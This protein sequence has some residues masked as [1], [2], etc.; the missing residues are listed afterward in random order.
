MSRGKTIKIVGIVILLVEIFCL[1]IPLKE[2]RPVCIKLESETEEDEPLYLEKGI[3]TVNVQY[4][5]ETDDN[6]LRI[7]TD[8]SHFNWIQHNDV[9]LHAWYQN[10]TSTLW[11]KDEQAPI[12][13]SIVN[14][15]DSV[16]EPAQIQLSG[17][18]I[19][20]NKTTITYTV[21][22]W[23]VRFVCLDIVLFLFIKYR[24]GMR[25]SPEK[26]NGILILGMILIA[27]SYPLFTN[28]LTEGHDKIYHLMRIETIKDGLKA[29]MFPV[30]IDPSWLN[31][32]GYPASV[33]Y[34]D[35]LM[36]PAAILRLIGLKLQDC[37]K[38]YIVMVN[39]L[40]CWVSYYC[41]RQIFQNENV[42]LAGSA[43][44]TL[45]Y[46]RFIDI[47]IRG[48]AGEYTAMVFIPLVICGLYLIYEEN[49]AKHRRGLAMAVIG[50]TGLLE[51]HLLTTEIVGLFTVVICLI[52]FKRT[53]QKQRFISLCKVVIYTILVNAGFLV[54]LFDYYGRNFYISSIETGN[55]SEFE[56]AALFPTQLFQVF[57]TGIGRSYEQSVGICADMPITCG[58]VLWIIAGL[59]LYKR[60]KTGIERYSALGDIMLGYA[61][62]GAVLTTTLF[63]YR[64]LSKY[65]PIVGKLLGS[66]Q[67]PWR[68]LIVPTIAIAVVFCVLLKNMSSTYGKWFMCVCILGITML[69][70]TY[71][72]DAWYNNHEPKLYYDINSINV[73]TSVGGGEYLLLGS[74]ASNMVRGQT[75]EYSGASINHIEYGDLEIYL[76]CTGVPEQETRISLPLSNYYGYHAEDVDS[77]TEVTVENG[78]ENMVTVVLPAGYQGT[79][80]VKWS[81]PWYWR[82]AELVSLVSVIAGLALWKRKNKQ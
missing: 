16:Q 81:E 4:Q 82:V 69:S 47:Y 21:F 25:I 65:L 56:N 19:T 76:D 45:S 18:T 39:S 38:F 67:F 36:Y 30:K 15:K 79:M 10:E 64:R 40:T 61:G 73:D 44:Y 11:V 8:G 9:T 43:L 78:V 17:I 7:Y 27:S 20:K 2:Y 46:Y 74:S 68:F 26:K 50:F 29:G 54:P 22:W 24:H 72:V 42:A 32:Y 33:F 77:K 14:S 63:P 23:I 80:H 28:Y 62:I 12:W 1:F 70:N 5:S 59:Y 53:F 51:T 71:M 3:Y 57:H 6:A 52:M 55:L 49:T 41:F 48:A 13:I 75:I 34:G 31:G 66:L 37:Y 58:V 60:N 35:L